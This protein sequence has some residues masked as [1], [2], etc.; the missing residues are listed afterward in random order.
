MALIITSLEKYSTVK[1]ELNLLLL[2][3][4]LCVLSIYHLAS[5]EL[6]VLKVSYEAM[7]LLQCVDLEVSDVIVWY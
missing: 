2:K 4:T 7:Y 3:K 5:R 1:I 6:F